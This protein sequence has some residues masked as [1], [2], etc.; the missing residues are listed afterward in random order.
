[1][2]QESGY[3]NEEVSGAKEKSFPKLL[4][5]L[6]SPPLYGVGGRGGNTGARC[7]RLI[8]PPGPVPSVLLQPRLGPKAHLVEVELAQNCILASS[9]LPGASFRRY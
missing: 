2:V 8:W 4:L 6:Q 5:G 1:M 7:R 3:A 9:F